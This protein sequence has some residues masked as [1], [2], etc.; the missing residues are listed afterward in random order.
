M[1]TFSLIHT[2]RLAI[3]NLPIAPFALPNCPRNRLGANGSNIQ[4]N[5]KY[6]DQLSNGSLTLTPSHNLRLGWLSHIFTYEDWGG[7]VPF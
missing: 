3:H 4:R 6:L 5:G 2:L 7:G 1:L